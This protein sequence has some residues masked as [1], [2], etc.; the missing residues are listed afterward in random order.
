MANRYTGRNLTAV[1]Q[2]SEPV[3][4]REGRGIAISIV[5]TAFTGT[6]TLQRR[7]SPSDQD[8]RNWKQYTAQAEDTLIAEADMEIR[9]YATAVSGGSAK[10]EARVSRERHVG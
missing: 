10:A 1:D 6:V 2:V 7:F 8:W 4:A 5:P 9:F 3:V